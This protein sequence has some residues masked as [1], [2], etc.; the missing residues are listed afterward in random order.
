[1]ILNVLNSNRENVGA[2]DVDAPEIAG[3]YDDG[4]R[5]YLP[6]AAATFDF[7]VNKFKNGK[8]IDGLENLNKGACFSFIKNGRAFVVF[9][10]GTS[11]MVEDDETISFQCISLERE[12]SLEYVGAFENTAAHSVGWY[13]EKNG[14]TNATSLIKIGTNEIDPRL[15]TLSWDGEATKADRLASIMTNFD[16]EYNFTYDLTPN[17]SVKGITLDIVK[18]YDGANITGVGRK[19]EDVTLTFGKHVKNVQV[20]YDFSNLFNA[21]TVTGK[22]GASWKAGSFK[23][24]DDAGEVL[25]IKNAGD[26]TAYAPQSAAAYPAHLSTSI[27][28]SIRR[29]FST[30]YT[31]AADMAAYGLR[32]LRAY[33]QPIATYTLAVSSAVVSEAIGDGEPLAVGDIVR[34]LD[35]NFKNE[36][37]ST[38]LFLT[39]RVVE[40]YTSESNPENNELVLSNV[41]RGLSQISTDLTARVTELVEAATPYRLELSNSNGVAFVNNLT[42]A[43]TTLNAKLFKGTKEITP[44]AFKWEADGTTLS[45]AASVEIKATSVEATKVVTFTASV[46]GE[47]VA[48]QSVTLTNTND[49]ANGAP[50][51][52]GKTGATG[53]TGAPGKDGADGAPGA[54]GKDG[55]DGA[56]GKPTGLTQSD[57]EPAEKFNGMLWQYTGATQITAGGVT[58]L[59]NV[60]Y[61]YDV[62]KWKIYA[63]DVANLTVDTLA[64]ITA[65]LG[66]VTAG[67]IKSYI[68]YTYYNNSATGVEAKAYLKIDANNVSQKIGLQSQTGTDWGYIKQTPDGLTIFTDTQNAGA[69]GMATGRYVMTSYSGAGISFINS[70][71]ATINANGDLVPA[72]AYTGQGWLYFDGTSVVSSKPIKATGDTDGWVDI[73]NFFN[74]FSGNLKYRIQGGWLIIR[75]YKVNVPTLSANTNVKM[76]QIAG[77]DLRYLNDTMATGASDFYVS[78]PANING[79]ADGS[80][81]FARAAAVTDGYKLNGAAVMPL[82]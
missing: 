14:I 50:G 62:S 40:L 12:L 54:D 82:L 8:L 72:Q 17:G 32:Q 63:I 79:T 41:T 59:P 71:T 39:A 16:A 78:Y 35:M 76:A 52:D 21:T 5:T 27:D 31:S 81:Y 25:Y 73:T 64:A 19:R 9:P 18:E 48:T 7:T 51:A 34:V 56:D 29:D 66:E 55:N 43:S 13:L 30:E 77:V 74:G 67:V 11:G 28:K 15:I 75:A 23:E 46:S 37:G 38:G 57:T 22:D 1:M 44:E 42:P 80:I 60:Q 20:A 6:E 10:S 36:D 61:I 70:N 3:Y 24:L 2:L 65:D 58:I 33:S 45:T 26:L 49:G 68:D 4:L 47:A 53:A 69:I